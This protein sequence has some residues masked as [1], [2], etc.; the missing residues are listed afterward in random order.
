MRA[1]EQYNAINDDPYWA[2]YYITKEKYEEL[3]AFTVNG[4]S[5]IEHYS[6]GV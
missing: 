5:W 2:R 3:K 4:K 6:K 1:F